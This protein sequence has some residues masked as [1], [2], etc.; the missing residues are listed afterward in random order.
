[1]P[2]ECK[3]SDSVQ[4]T[5][6]E[7][8]PRS[9]SLHE[10]T[11]QSFLAK[12]RTRA[13][14]PIDNASLIFF[15]I[16][17][18]LLMFWEVCRYFIHGWISRYW[19]NSEFQFT[20]YGFSWIHLW[21]GNGMYVHWAILGLLALF[22]AIGFFYR[23][24][25][26]LFFLGFTYCFLLD[27][28]T[29]LNHFYLICLL[30]FLLSFVPANRS[31]AI[32]AWFR[33]NLRSQT[34]PPWTLWLLRGQLAIV[35]F[36]GGIAKISPDWLRGEPMR[37]WL[38]RRIDFPIIGHFFRDEWLVYLLSY[39]GLL[40]DLLI[41][42]ALLWRRTRVPAFCIAVLFHLMNARLFSIG[43][44]PWLAIAA[45]TLFLSPSWPRR[46]LAIFFSPAVSP[47]S[48]SEA[49]PSERKQMLV[50]GLAA[51]YIVIQ[52]VVPLRHLLYPG[53]VD[54]TYE[55][56]R[57][58]WRMKLLD[59]DAW[60]RFFI[61]DPSTAQT[62]WVDP[63]DILSSRQASKMAARPDMILQFAHYLAAI[64]PRQGVAPL[65]VR[66][67]VVVSLNGREPELL[68]DPKVDLA[69]E[70]RSL[71]PARWLLPMTKRLPKPQR[72]AVDFEKTEPDELS[73]D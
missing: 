25:I 69:T 37:M 66:A 36:F 9:T 38:A 42:P 28:T 41:A 12:V 21:P 49:P 29:Y 62:V 2:E 20:Y 51:I 26:I 8:G 52:L 47:P 68:A 18:G 13:F 11:A 60:T 1:M 48:E 53:R 14:A 43:I 6:I 23:L 15:R 65:Q 44:F 24:S 32:D 30:S 55:G 31:L 40:L 17:F 64:M 54:W 34:T 10:P 39:G 57:F 56:H 19:I 70:K 58:S 46:V 59:R 33:P 3:T 73:G 4:I 27:Q 22:I 16:A 67:R 35:Y 72:Y 7:R 50:L 45:T 61:T 63:R 5:D 71:L